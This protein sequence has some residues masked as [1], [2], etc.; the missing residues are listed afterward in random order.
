MSLIPEA[1]VTMQEIIEWEDKKK[2]L[3]VLKVEEMALRMRIYKHFFKTPQEGTND[4]PLSEGWLLKAQR[5]IDRKVDLGSL[6]AL[7]A[8]GGLFHQKGIN[9]N[10]LI[11]WSPELKLKEYRAL[12]ESMQEIFNQALI[13]KD[14]SPQLDIVLPA[15]AKKAIAKK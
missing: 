5:K 9:A 3:A 15:A 7:A 10:L 1:P 4:V 12:P 13:I 8:E 14:G 11:Q 2:K 6:Q